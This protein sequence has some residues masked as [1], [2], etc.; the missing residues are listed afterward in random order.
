MQRLD[1]AHCRTPSP[2]EFAGRRGPE[3]DVEVAKSN[4]PQPRIGV[5]D[6]AGWYSVSQAEVI[7]CGL[8]VNENPDLI[9]PRHGVDDATGGWWAFLLSQGVNVGRS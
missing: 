1:D 8:A 4:R 6:D 3:G 9:T 5:Y 2:V 7:C